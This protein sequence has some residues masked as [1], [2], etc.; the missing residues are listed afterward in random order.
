MAVNKA[1]I[2]CNRMPEEI[3]EDIMIDKM[4]CVMFDDENDFIEKCKYYLEHEEERKEIVNNAYKY[5]L[6]R[7]MWKHKITHLID[8]LGGA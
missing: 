2:M 6:E 1:L 4:N 7:H 8:N 5:F 3:Y